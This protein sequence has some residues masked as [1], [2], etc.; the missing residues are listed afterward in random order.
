MILKTVFSLKFYLSV[1]A[2]NSK[3]TA[4]YDMYTLLLQFKKNPTFS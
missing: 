2:S 1:T 4:Y 3:S